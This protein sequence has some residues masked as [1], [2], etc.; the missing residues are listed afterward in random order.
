[1]LAAN[2]EDPNTNE[3]L[4][5]LLKYSFDKI[6]IV[7]DFP[8]CYVTSAIAVGVELE[9]CQNSSNQAHELLTQDFIMYV[10]LDTSYFSNFSQLKKKKILNHKYRTL[11]VSHTVSNVLKFF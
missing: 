8:S 11:M 10:L 2:H 6:S 7:V 3:S 4:K 5:P 1:L 9:P